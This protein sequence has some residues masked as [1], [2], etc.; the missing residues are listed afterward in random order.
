MSSKDNNPGEVPKTTRDPGRD[1]TALMY[2]DATG[3]LRER[4]A[5]VV[6]MSGDDRGKEVTLDGTLLVGSHENNDLVLSDPTVSRYHLE[7][8]LLSDGILV[9]DLDSTNGTT[10]EGSR[11]K[12]LILK[13]SSTVRAGKTELALVLGD[14]T[15]DVAPSSQPQF[16]GVVGESMAMRRLFGLLARVAPTD[17]TV[18]MEG[19]TGTGKEVL[20]EAIHR[21]SQRAQKPFVVVD[22]SAIPR[23]LIEAELFG[24][25]KGAFTGAVANRAGY[26][27]EA[28]GGTIFL[29]EVGELELDLQPKLLRVLDRRELRRVGEVKPR[30]IDVRVVAA[31][32][33][34]LRAMVKEGKFRED[35]YFRLA[36][37]SVP[38]PSLRERRDDIPL[39][40][41]HFIR[42]M[43][44]KDFR[45]STGTMERLQAYEWPGNVRELR[46]LVERAVSLSDENQAIPNSLSEGRGLGG[47]QTPAGQVSLPA[48]SPSGKELVELPFKEAKGMLIEAFEREYLVNL[49]DRHSGNISRAALE[50]GIDR[51]YIHR[52]IK[53]YGLER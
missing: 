38:I 18:L 42:H 12:E 43:G 15:V 11:V 28:D 41:A 48:G 22:C 14:E 51:N 34:D 37:V 50:A 33:R 10:Y 32:N 44:R 6:V 16:G 23:E 29:D 1:G 40:V 39:L 8:R 36:V 24:H 13:G 21:H 49:L 46:N 47:A 25:T 53:K 35:L 30:P 27:E 45:L 7:I 9:R 31:T 17:A 5:R 3:T 26:F 2:T 52:L 20:A 19:E 4:V